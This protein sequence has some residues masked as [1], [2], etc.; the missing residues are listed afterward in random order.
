MNRIFIIAIAMVTLIASTSAALAMESR[1]SKAEKAQLKTCLES[2]ACTKVLKETV[3]AKLKEI[4][5]HARLKP[6]RKP[7]AEQLPAK[8]AEEKQPQ[9]VRPLD[10]GPKDTHPVTPGQPY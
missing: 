5:G 2:D 7:K 4:V 9:H 8:P 3:R 1:L 6:K 10:E